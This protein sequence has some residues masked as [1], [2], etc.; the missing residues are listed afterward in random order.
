MSRNVVVIPLPRL[1][2]LREDYCSQEVT[3][4]AI[5]WLET[6]RPDLIEN[7]M[8]YEHWRQQDYREAACDILEFLTEQKIPIPTT[9]MGR[10]DLVAELTRRGR[11]AAGLPEIAPSGKPL[12][13]GPDEPLPS[14]AD[15]EICERSK[16]K[17]NLTQEMADRVLPIA[18]DRRPDLWIAAAEEHR[19]E[20]LLD[21][22]DEFH[23]L[24]REIVNAEPSTPAATICGRGWTYTRRASCAFTTCAGSSSKTL[25]PFRPHPSYAACARHQGHDERTETSPLTPDPGR[26]ETPAA[27][28]RCT[29]KHFP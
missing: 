14:L 11:S 28:R 21:A 16:Q 10:M 13:A 17:D 5:G 20:V 6:H 9:L 27:L 7:L 15:L 18:Y 3:D 1:K 12:A 19:Y 22:T 2:V 26:E 8:L 24:L 25:P 4:L 29:K 23:A